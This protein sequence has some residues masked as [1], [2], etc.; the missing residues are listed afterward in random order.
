MGAEH[1]HGA[2]SAAAPGSDHRESERPK[3]LGRLPVA[4]EAPE[5]VPARMINEVRPVEVVK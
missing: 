4:S 3:T 2:P 5:L 1:D